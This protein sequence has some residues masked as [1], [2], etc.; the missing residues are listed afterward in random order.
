M[1]A[2][3]GTV[4]LRNLVT[5]IVEN[6]QPK[7]LMGVSIDITERKLAE[8]AQ[9]DLPQRLL[10]AQEEERASI[11]RELHDGIG[12]NLAILAITL[13]RLE[14][15]CARD[16]EKF[17]LARESH[18]LTLKVADDIRR[19]S[20]GL[21]PSS[22]ALLGLSA[23]VRQKCSEFGETTNAAVHQDI[24]ILPSNL[25]NEV[26]TSVYRVLQECLHNVLKHS[27]ARNI[28]VKLWVESG[29]IR[30]RVEDDGVGFEPGKAT[31][32]Q[33]LGL[34]SMNERVHLVRGSLQLRS[35]PGE[36]T[37]VD[38]RIPFSEV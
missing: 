25:P 5:V 13:S 20:H 19:L 1:A 11:A 2:D 3:G 32:A 8:E 4:W 38:V 14:K 34:A 31:T 23:A 6:G 12:Q 26:V 17:A 35:T 28:E 21:H 27:K 33:G 30:L 37:Q 36:G 18:V 9:R 29:E 15:D 10:R 22:L 24:D 16:R 7:E